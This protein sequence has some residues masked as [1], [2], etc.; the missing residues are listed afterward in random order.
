[1][2]LTSSRLRPRL[3]AA[4]VFALALPLALAGRIS[5]GSYN[6][7]A[8]DSSG[9]VWVWGANFYGQ[10]C[11]GT[12]NHRGVPAPLP[13]LSNAA[14]VSA[15]GSHGLAQKANG[16]AAAWGL[17]SADSS[18]RGGG[19]L[20]DGSQVNKGAPVAVT[21]IAGAWQV[22]A[23][24]YHSLAVMGDTSVRAWGF[25]NTSQLGDGSVITRTTPIMVAGLSGVIAVAAGCQHSLALKLDGTVWAWGYNSTGQLGD[26]SNKDKS[27]PV[28]VSGLSNVAAIAAGC[29]H[30]LALKNDGTL[31]AWGF[32][33]DGE[34]GGATASFISSKPLQITTLS[35]VSAI[36]A[37][38]YFSLALKADG[39]VWSWGK[40]DLGQLGDGSTA[41]R[42]LPMQVAVPASTDISAGQDFA[43]ALNASGSLS[44]WGNNNYGQLGIGTTS[45]ASATPVTVKDAAGTAFIVGAETTGDIDRIYDFAQAQYPQLFNNKT[46]SSSLYGYRLRAYPSGVVIAARDGRIYV[47]GGPFGSL[48][49]DV[50]AAAS[51]LKLAKQA[52][53]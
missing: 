48:L 21:D 40:N 16:S 10:L 45:G 4:S 42:P 9:A 52:G 15:G 20:G 30:S 53:F 3:F 27:T 36:A 22:V 25:N 8:V 18:G 43:L 17:N 19:Q 24:Q 2:P 1:M 11:D 50:G 32:N 26:A 28:Q 46:T 37:G 51:Y 47:L 7:Y 31:W 41:N 13:N 35:G 34:L 5:A 39:T 23:G 44:A 38:N 33:A 49:L 29:A 14:T 6:G 12:T